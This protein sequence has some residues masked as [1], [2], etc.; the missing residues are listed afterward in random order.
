VRRPAL[1]SSHLGPQKA[2]GFAAS[3]QQI[4][5]NGRQYQ[6]GLKGAALDAH[7]KDVLSRDKAFSAQVYRAWQ[8]PLRSVSISV[9]RIILLIVFLALLS[10]AIF[11]FFWDIPVEQERVEKPLDQRVLRD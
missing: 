1:K 5:G 4:A 6:W 11:L 10:G 8:R 9:I 7:F 3:A 2:C